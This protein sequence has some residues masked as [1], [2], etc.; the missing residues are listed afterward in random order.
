MKTVI[1]ISKETKKKQIKK[2]I[3][4]SRAGME[5]ITRLAPL[6]KDATLENIDAGGVPAAWMITPGVAKDRAILYLHGGGYTVGSIT[7]HQDLTQ[8]ISKV[9][10]TRVLILDYR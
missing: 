8:R 6:H 7:S 9:S 5:E 10:N 3:E 4:E 2:R 1:E